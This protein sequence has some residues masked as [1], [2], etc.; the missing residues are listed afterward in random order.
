MAEAAAARYLEARGVR[1]LARGFTALRG[2]IDIVAR[3]GDDLVFV[4]VRARAPG[5][6]VGGIESVTRDKRR[7]VAR[8]A[9]AYVVRRGF[10]DVPVRFDIVEV[11][12]TPDGVVE[13]TTWLQEAFTLDDC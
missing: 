12:I 7:N 8:A 2:E 4:E 3:D 6:A 1:I 13:D 10:E 9:T 11:R 5:A